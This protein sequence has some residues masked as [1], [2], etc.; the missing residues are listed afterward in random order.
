[1]ITTDTISLDYG[2]IVEANKVQN[3]QNIHEIGNALS[4]YNGWVGIYNSKHRREGDKL[5][6]V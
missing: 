4:T 5:L 2:L 6:L 1:M 3:S